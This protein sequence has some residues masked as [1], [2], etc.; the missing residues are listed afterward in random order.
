MEGLSVINKEFIHLI[1]GA[2]VPCAFL[3]KYTLQSLCRVEVKFEEFQISTSQRVIFQEQ[4]KL[5]LFMEVD[6]NS[7]LL[8]WFGYSKVKK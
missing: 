2:H 6:T 3:L 5:L 4:E 7:L 8:Y 1:V